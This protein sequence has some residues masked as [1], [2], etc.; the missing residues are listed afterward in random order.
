MTNIVTTLTRSLLNLWRHHTVL[1]AHP[2]AG[3]DEAVPVSA[4]APLPVTVIGGGG[5]T[6]PTDPDSARE[7]TL[8]QVR[9]AVLALGGNTDGL[10]ALNLAQRDYLAALSTY[11]DQAESL[12][13]ALGSN[14]D[15]LEGLLAALGVKEDASTAKLEAVRLLLTAPLPLPADASTETTQTAVLSELGVI[16]TTLGTLTPTQ[17]TAT[18]TPEVLTVGAAETQLAAI[19]ALAN[20]ALVR[21]TAGEARMGYGDATSAGVET[22]VLLEGAQLAALRLIRSG[23]VD[24]AVRVDYWR[25]A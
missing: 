9:D 22:Q 11:L 2:G 3:N 6:A 13:T 12:L 25:E 7:V 23:T 24:A 19:P 1:L 21:V 15:G 14:T 5:S 20:R 16:N 17:V 4:A 18:F 8:E 10:E